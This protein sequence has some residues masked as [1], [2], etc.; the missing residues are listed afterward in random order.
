MILRSCIFTLA[1]VCAGSAHGESLS[2]PPMV[3][4]PYQPD[5]RPQ[6]TDPVK[7]RP[8]LASVYA[9]ANALRAAGIARTSLDRRFAEDDAVGSVGFLCGL[10]PSHDFSGGASAYGSDPQGRFLGAKLSRAF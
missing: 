2:Q 1:L 6:A 3:L 4:K 5:A 8:R 10:Q 7:A 9:E